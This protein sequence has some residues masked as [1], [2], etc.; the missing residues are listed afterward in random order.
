LQCCQT[1]NDIAYQ[2]KK[3]SNCESKSA[4]ISAKWNSP[5][6]IQ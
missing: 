3:P 4:Q 1:Q 5:L 2:I 6:A